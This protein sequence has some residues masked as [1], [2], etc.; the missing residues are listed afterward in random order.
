MSTRSIGTA[1][2]LATLLLPFELPAQTGE[3]FR[4]SFSHQGA[5]RSYRL[6]VPAD[7]DGSVAW[8]LVVDFHG[9]IQDELSQRRVDSMDFAADDADFLI[10]YA[11]GREVDFDGKVA[12]GWNMDGRRSDTDDVDFTRRLIEHVMEDYVIDSNRIHAVG[13]S[14]GA[15]MTQRLACDLSDQIA[16]VASVAGPMN[17]FILEECNPTRPIS[18]MVVHGTDD[19]EFTVTAPAETVDFWI[20]HDDCSP[21]PAVTE[22]DDVDPDDNSTVTM[23]AYSGCATDLTMETKVVYYSVDGGGHTWPGG[24]PFLPAATGQTNRDFNATTAILA[25]FTEHY[26]TVAM[27]DIRTNGIPTTASVVAAY[28]NPTAGRVTLDLELPD[29]SEI[30]MR[31]TNVL[32]RRFGSGIRRSLP[33]GRHAIPVDLGSTVTATGLYFIGIDLGERSL[34]VPVLYQT[35]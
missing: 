5:D 19:Q 1:L 35:P 18:I 29:A 22:L 15:M 14:L 8:P 11:R 23:Y 10:A 26:R 12:L 6:Y 27:E 34:S 17:R 33:A 25:F 31:V 7:Y 4:R 2:V 20:H 30:E 28:P 9:F 32:G 16:S 3:T 21:E 13:Y 24:G